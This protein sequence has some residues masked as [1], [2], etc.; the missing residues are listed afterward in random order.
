MKALDVNHLSVL[1][2]IALVTITF[3]FSYS[4]LKISEEKFASENRPYLYID[5]VE[6]VGNNNELFKI[7][8]I[9]PSNFPA[10]F[11]V[12]YTIY[13]SKKN[14]ILESNLYNEDYNLNIFPYEKEKTISFGYNKIQLTHPHTGKEI[15]LTKKG[16][17]EALEIYNSGSKIVLNLT[18]IYKGLSADL[19]DRF[20]YIQILEIQK[21]NNN[22]EIEI[23]NFIAN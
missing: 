17:G 11:F 12:E 19:N 1:V 2:Q 6:W 23:K 10:A 9:N 22:P 4:T 14:I 15:I 16:L 7:N 18:L 20:S 13:D 3:W 8:V 5:K 21:F